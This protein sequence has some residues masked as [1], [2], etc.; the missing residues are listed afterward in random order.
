MSFI[1]ICPECKQK[2]EAQDEWEGMEL[3]C[4]FC[5]H[6][7]KIEKKIP[8]LKPVFEKNEGHA[9]ESSGNTNGNPGENHFSND[10]FL[11]ICPECGIAS[12]L[13]ANM[14]GKIFTCPACGEDVTAIPSETRNCPHCDEE[15]NI[16][17]TFCKY[18]HKNVPSIK[19]QNKKN[20]NSFNGLK[21][22]KTAT[23]TPNSNE[24]RQ[25]IETLY[26][27]FFILGVIGIPLVSLGSVILKLSNTS[28]D[29]YGFG[30]VLIFVG[31]GPNIACLVFSAMLIYQYWKLVS[32]DKMPTTP[33]R[34][35][36]FLFIPIFNF[37]WGFVSLW[38]LGKAL[39]NETGE[40]DI[41]TATWGF[42]MALSICTMPLSNIEISG[43]VYSLFGHGASFFAI[44]AFH[45][46]ARKL[47]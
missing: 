25:Y 2:L 27:L 11:F 46:Q 42:V 4:P 33:G 47:L 40:N 37:Y 14:N 18:C 32:P 22:G 31:A 29:V 45:K 38:G 21:I 7:L 15:I 39:M 30:N 6:T 44:Q 41:D 43:W 5:H 8:V 26:K 13:K 35:V 24:R 16:K 12:E 3:P 19:P 9:R 10:S 20:G 1:F 34:A 36:G 23:E 28:S 17:A